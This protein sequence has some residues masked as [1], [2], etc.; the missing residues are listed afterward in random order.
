[1]VFYF[2]WFGSWYWYVTLNKNFR[3]L[4][5]TFKQGCQFCIFRVEMTKLRKDIFFWKTL[6][7]SLSFRI[8]RKKFL[9]NQRKKSRPSE[10]HLTCLEAKMYEKIFFFGLVTIL[11]ICS[12]C[13]VTR[14]ESSAKNSLVGS[15]N[16]TY[17]SKW[18]FGTKWLSF[19]PFK[20][21]FFPDFKRKI[22]SSVM[23]TYFYASRWP[24]EEW[25]FNS[26]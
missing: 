17:V 25:G 6:S 26:T 14:F 9:D 1:M 2:E 7:D 10:L 22:S 11:V 21:K 15:P 23:K 5:Q 16:C 13:D 12:D 19:G 18:K 8:L 24:Y 20:F 4:A 3:I